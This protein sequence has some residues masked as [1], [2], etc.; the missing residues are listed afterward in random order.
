MAIVL[1]ISAINII[2]PDTITAQSEKDM[3]EDYIRALSKRSSTNYV[4]APF[5][6]YNANIYSLIGSV[7]MD[8]YHRKYKFDDFDFDTLWKEW[9]ELY[10]VDVYTEEQYAYVFNDLFSKL[11]ESTTDESREVSM[12]VVDEISKALQLDGSIDKFLETDNAIMKGNYEKLDNTAQQAWDCIS[13]GMSKLESPS[14]AINILN[15][16]VKVI[17]IFERDYEKMS[18]YLD[19]I[20]KG[21]YEYINDESD[22]AK[23]VA[24]KAAF[25]KV[26][27]AYHDKISAAMVEYSDGLMEQIKGIIEKN[28]TAI[29]SIALDSPLVSRFLVAVSLV[30]DIKNLYSES[31]GIHQ[32]VLS[33][34]NIIHMCE[35]MCHFQQFFIAEGEK[36]ISDGKFSNEDYDYMSKLFKICGTIQ[37]LN[38]LYA[39]TLEIED[40][41]WYNA[42][43][44][45]SLPNDK[46]GFIADKL[47]S[48]FLLKRY[49]DKERQSDIK[50]IA[51]AGQCGEAMYWEIDSN[52]NLL[53][54]GSG[55]MFHTT[56]EKTDIMRSGF[57]VGCKIWEPKE[58]IT[59][60]FDGNITGIGNDAF[61]GTPSTTNVSGDMLENLKS[62]E[63]PES[64]VTISNYA[65]LNCINLESINIPD[66]VR[67][68]GDNAFSGCSKLKDITMPD[69]V[70]YIGSNAFSYTAITN[71][72]DLIP[73]NVTRLEAGMFSGTP[74]QELVVPEHITKIAADFFWDMDSLETVYMLTRHDII[75]IGAH[76]AQGGYDFVVYGYENAE[77]WVHDMNYAWGDMGG[78]G[79]QTS[80]IEY[81]EL[82]SDIMIPGMEANDEEVSSEINGELYTDWSDDASDED[83]FIEFMSELLPICIGISIGLFFI[84]RKI[85]RSRKKNRHEDDDTDDESL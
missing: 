71:A 1:I 76:D 14:D 80:S 56:V 5:E 49:L 74:I 83:T 10:G 85:V 23:S 58:V 51:D 17:V 65:F 79:P 25:D 63:L 12:D 26:Y 57:P 43:K 22:S 39:D 15:N 53:I 52:G 67:Y 28:G 66:G 9:M 59:V 82:T 27:Y 2:N 35:I 40:A 54:F 6:E 20:K 45:M 29:T 3:M 4:Y 41:F 31:S 69:S 11:S 32:E 72:T 46:Y 75:E 36:R 68:I 44:A 18:G 47:S 61:G 30:I 78:Y 38:Y 73:P 77:K 8:D 16:V 33:T 84:I 55:D 81:R 24:I 50:D 48:E 19:V 13:L 62:V 7:D 64:L 21:V 42:R 34:G 37:S 60:R 70:E